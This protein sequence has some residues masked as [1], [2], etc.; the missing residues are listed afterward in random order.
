MMRATYIIL[1]WWELASIGAAYTISS[2]NTVYLLVCVCTL[3]Y[4][5]SVIFISVL[6]WESWSRVHL[7]ALSSYGRE[8]LQKAND[9]YLILIM[10]TVIILYWVHVARILSATFHYNWDYRLS[11]LFC[12]GD[13]LPTLLLSSPKLKHQCAEWNEKEW[14]SRLTRGYAYVCKHIK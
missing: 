9:N 6:T 8:Q 1:W 4:I 5:C 3:F 13:T 2:Y 11:W 12:C 7:M 10:T 14:M